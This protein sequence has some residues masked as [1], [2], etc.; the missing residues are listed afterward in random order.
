MTKST[1]ND[2]AMVSITVAVVPAIIAALAGIIGS[3][4][5]YSAGIEAIRVPLNATQTAEAKQPLVTQA[6]TPTQFTQVTSAPIAVDSRQSWQATGIQISEH[7]TVNIK[8]TGGQW[9]TARDKI[10]AEWKEQLKGANGYYEN[11]QI[12]I[13][14][15]IESDGSG[16]SSIFCKNTSCPMPNFNVGILVARIGN[17]V[18]SIGNSCSFT[19]E[20]SGQLFLMVNDDDLS[21]NAGVL[22]V[23]INLNQND[24]IQKSSVCGNTYKK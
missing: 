20:E 15:Q 13:N 9:T 19:V 18:Y 8:V 11:S 12:W 21:S 17:V 5:S 22:A 23:A 1:R 7:D 16:S 4:F 2:K 14:W 24:Y 3:Y 6:V 10:P